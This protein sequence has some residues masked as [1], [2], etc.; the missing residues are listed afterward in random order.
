M[1]TSRRRGLRRSTT[2]TLRFS[3]GPGSVSLVF[4]TQI[5]HCARDDADRD[6][7]AEPG[8][9]HSTTLPQRHGMAVPHWFDNSKIRSLAR[10]SEADLQNRDREGAVTQPSLSAI[11]PRGSNETGAMQMNV[12]IISSLEDVHAR[13]VMEALSARGAA[14]ELLDLAEFPTRL[15]LAMAFEDGERRFVLRREGG[16]RLDLSSVSAVWWRRPQPFDLPATVTDPAHRR[17]AI[18]E[19]ETA[20]AGLYNSLDAFWINDPRRDAAAHH[21]PWQLAVAQ[22]IGLAIPATLM[23][24]DPEEARDFWRRNEGNVIHKVFRAFPEAW[25]ETRRL[26][27][28]DAALADTIK[29]TPVIFQR[30]VEAVADIRVTVIG[31]E[32]YAA[33]ADARQGEYPVDFRF[34]PDLRWERHAL[35]SAVENALLDLMQ[36]MGLEYG[37][38]DLRLTPEGE[39]VFLEINP[40]GQFLWVE[41]ATG[42]KIASA[43]AGCLMGGPRSRVAAAGKR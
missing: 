9:P 2:E 39:Y 40:A 16:G 4:G 14:V 41:I 33:S 18:S 29:L 13:A 22:E 17:F 32:I 1:R 31:D 36:R 35:P 23:T 21:K 7:T 5:P 34:N 25:R 11:L 30:F 38:I 20:F 12:L 26:R 8:L 37:A 24:N 15:A 19:A 42:Q 43:L 10:G 27:P 6:S 3:H 28:E